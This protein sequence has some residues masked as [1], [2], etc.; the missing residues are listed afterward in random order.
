MG[1]F[2][3]GYHLEP[4]PIFSLVIV[5]FWKLSRHGKGAC[6]WTQLFIMLPEQC[7]NGLGS[8]WAFRFPNMSSP[9]GIISILLSG[10]KPNLKW[11]KWLKCPSFSVWLLG[12][13]LARH[14]KWCG[15]FKPD[16]CHHCR[17][18]RTLVTMWRIGGRSS[19]DCHGKTLDTFGTSMVCHG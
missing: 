6:S 3:R 9:E 4:W 2:T 7:W 11:L 17:V 1:D 8:P 14:C 12:V 18:C 16:R 10:G 13:P 19:G 15:K 5:G